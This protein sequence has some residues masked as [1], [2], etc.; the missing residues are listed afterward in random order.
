METQSIKIAIA[1]REYPFKIN[2]IEE[3]LIRKAAKR[4]NEK[5]EFF[6][7]KFPN[8]DIQDAF[9]M[10]LL[11]FAMSL[12]E[13]EQNQDHTILLKELDSLDTELV[14]YIKNTD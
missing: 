14:E 10:S 12:I 9:S 6:K 13:K 2:P 3:E 1:D 8:R 11:Q 4:I 7:A 5:V